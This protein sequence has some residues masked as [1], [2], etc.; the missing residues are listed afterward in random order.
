MFLSLIIP[1]PNSPLIDIDVCFRPL[2]DELKQLRSSRALIYDVSR[3]HN[4]QIKTVLMRTV[5]FPAYEM[6]SRWSTHGK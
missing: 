6:V 4:F 3:K 2:I 1:G 5:N